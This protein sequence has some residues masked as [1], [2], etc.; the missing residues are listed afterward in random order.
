MIVVE[1]KSLAKEREHGS[2]GEGAGYGYP[3]KDPLAGH[4]GD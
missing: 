1:M 2:D 4:D 3:S